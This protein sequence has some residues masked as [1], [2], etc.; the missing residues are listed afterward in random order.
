MLFSCFSKDNYG[1]YL[2]KPK[3]DHQSH[4]LCTLIVDTAQEAPQADAGIS[5]YL[6]GR[7][8]LGL[9]QRL[10]DFVIH[11]SLLPVQ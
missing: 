8:G 10:A 3:H 4:N 11:V 1:K 5:L 7:R 6:P 9:P 2:I